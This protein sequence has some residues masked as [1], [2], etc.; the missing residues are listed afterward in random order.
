MKDEIEKK[1]QLKLDNLAEE[2]GEPDNTDEKILNNAML[3]W[4]FKF[5]RFEIL[6]LRYF[7]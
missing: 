2:E 5:I 3:S 1:A 6:F 4:S 7:Q